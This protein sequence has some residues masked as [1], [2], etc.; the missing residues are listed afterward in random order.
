[1]QTLTVQWK[2]CVFRKVKAPWNNVGLHRLRW[3][4]E[5]E[6]W[7]NIQRRLPQWPASK[8]D[9]GEEMLPYF[10]FFH[11]AKCPSGLWWHF[12]NTESFPGIFV[13]LAG[14]RPRACLSGTWERFR[15]QWSDN[16]SIQCPG[17]AGEPADQA[18]RQSQKYGE[19]WGQECELL[20]SGL[21][22]RYSHCR[23]LLSPQF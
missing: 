9:Q 4:K 15:G 10:I 14:M 19:F 12:S 3:G 8:L 23:L 17:Q 11:G 13:C 1:M 7:R 21:E 5:L 16:W 18:P 22:A 6:G 2:G 20:Q